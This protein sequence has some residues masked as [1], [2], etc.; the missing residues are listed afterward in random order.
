MKSHR[1]SIIRNSA[2]NRGKLVS[3]PDIRQFPE[4][5]L[6]FR[7]AYTL[8]TINLSGS[9][10]DKRLGIYTSLFPASNYDAIAGPPDGRLIELDSTRTCATDEIFNPWRGIGRTTCANSG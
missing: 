8:P 9:V 5:E 10:I 4:L 3:T 6:Y 7:S 2:D 1:M